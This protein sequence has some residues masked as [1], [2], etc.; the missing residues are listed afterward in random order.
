[1]SLPLSK[2]QPHPIERTTAYTNFVSRPGVRNPRA[3]RTALQRMLRSCAPAAIDEL[4]GIHL[5]HGVG[6]LIGEGY[7]FSY[8]D[9]S[10]R[11]LKAFYNWALRNGLCTSN[12]CEGVAVPKSREGSDP[13]VVPEPLLAKC[14][15]W[16]VAEGNGSVEDILMWAFFRAGCRVSEPCAVRKRHISIDPS[17]KTWTCWVGWKTKPR[18]I[19]MPQWAYRYAEAIC[20]SKAEP[21]D[22]VL[23]LKGTRLDD[24]LSDE[25]QTRQIEVRTKNA[26]VRL[27]E[28]QRVALGEIHFNPKDMRSTFATV[29]LRA[30]PMQWLEVA[31]HLGHSPQVLMDKYAA[32]LRS[33]DFSSVMG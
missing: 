11:A 24:S 15:G 25:D 29:A 31:Q 30:N 1:M 23:Y 26:R 6:V 17:N 33:A 9:R 2:M 18:K 3:L 20:A 12:P 22:L 4:S 16:L 8:I 21:N 7:S 10:M 13:I 28:I 19:K 32:L 14:Q 5:E 27:D